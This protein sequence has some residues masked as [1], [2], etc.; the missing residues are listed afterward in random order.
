VSA[1]RRAVR[2]ILEDGLRHG[3]TSLD[4]L[5]YLLPDGR[6]GTYVERLAVYGREGEPCRRCGTRIEKATIAQRSSHYCPECQR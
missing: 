1:L 6:A 3:G 2:P 5:A 4:D